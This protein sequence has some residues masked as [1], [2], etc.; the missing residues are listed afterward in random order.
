LLFTLQVGT[1]KQEASPGK[2]FMAFKVM[3]SNHPNPD[4]VFT[5]YAYKGD[6]KR[7]LYQSYNLC[8]WRREGANHMR[9]FISGARGSFI[10]YRSESYYA[11][12]QARSDEFLAVKVKCIDYNAKRNRVQ[13]DQMVELVDPPGIEQTC[14]DGKYN[15]LELEPLSFEY[16]DI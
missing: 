14:R 5:L 4:G 2:L 16:E 15:E 10:F 9:K 6:L 1:H 3:D 12:E 11:W 8:L 13:N 7:G